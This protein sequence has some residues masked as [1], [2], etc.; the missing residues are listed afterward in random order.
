MVLE[1]MGRH[2]G[3]IAL[4]AGIAGGAD[5][6][7][8]PE[9]KS[10]IEVVAEQVGIKEH[11]GKDFAKLMAGKK[12]EIVKKILTVDGFEYAGKLPGNMLYGKK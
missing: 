2:A 10:E 5:V 4:H 7:L 11:L 3:W 6:I 9:T 12:D 1:V 8:M